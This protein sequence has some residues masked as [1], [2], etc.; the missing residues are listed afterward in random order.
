MVSD[1]LFGAVMGT[2]QAIS[3]KRDFE[4]EVFAQDRERAARMDELRE[5]YRLQ[6]ENSLAVERERIKQQDMKQQADAESKISELTNLT[7][8]L[9]PDRSPEEIISAAR[10]M[11]SSGLIPSTVAQ[12]QDLVDMFMQGA[13]RNLYYGGQG[14]GTPSGA[15]DVS[16]SR[17]DAIVNGELPTDPN[18]VDW[19][20]WDAE[21]EASVPANE[22][23]TPD[24]APAPQRPVVTT[25]PI[26]QARTEYFSDKVP[27]GGI[28][29]TSGL[30]KGKYTQD[31]NIK[32]EFFEK[33]G[34]LPQGVWETIKQQKA[35]SVKNDFPEGSRNTK[36]YA[37]LT[38]AV[39]V[40]NRGPDFAKK[41]KEEDVPNTIVSMMETMVEDAMLPKQ[42]VTNE[43]GDVWF[44]Y[45]NKTPILGQDDANRIRTNGKELGAIVHI[46]GAS[47]GSDSLFVSKNSQND[48]LFKAADLLFGEMRK[49]APKV[50]HTSELLVLHK[51]ALQMIDNATGGLG[52]KIMLDYYAHKYGIGGGSLR[53]AV[54]EYT[55]TAV[56]SRAAAQAAQDQPAPTTAQEGEA[57]DPMWV[58]VARRMGVSVAE[59]KKVVGEEQAPA[60]QQQAT[61][62]PEKTADTLTGNV[63]ETMRP[64]LAEK[65]KVAPDD[66]VRIDASRKDRAVTVY[67]QDGTV[68][69][70]YARSK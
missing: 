48:L 63:F 70:F 5:T 7:R 26:G 25:S 13:N 24:A 22:A 20:A 40:S 64:A 10:A 67:L 51:G 21:L 2:A 61:R 23:G 55:K 53:P 39:P 30:G 11:S 32:R 49:D 66:I 29:K 44:G 65:M 36:V 4:R 15:G 47:Q 45:V 6:G 50:S 33:K 12:N 46:L 3:S 14:V 68:K 19:K 16:Q 69:Q 1:I 18:K 8:T 37:A 58:K 62:L 17:R 56:S 60:P 54:S 38:A 35:S 41:V 27:F 9:F 34:D 42:E 31:G 28:L 59:A 43:Y 52:S 57:E